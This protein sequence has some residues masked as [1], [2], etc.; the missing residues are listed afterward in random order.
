MGFLK[1]L[2]KSIIL[3]V[4]KG[5]IIET[6]KNVKHQDIITAIKTNTN[7]YDVINMNPN[8]RK[9]VLNLRDLYRP[10]IEEYRTLITPEAIIEWLRGDRPDIA[11]L[12]VNTRN[13]TEWLSRQID[14]IIDGLTRNE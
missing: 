11:S 3:E 5:F 14:A 6:I 13:G 8:I 4:I 1:E 10:Y 2:S 7:L 9:A 12:I